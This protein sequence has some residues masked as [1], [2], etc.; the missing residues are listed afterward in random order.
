MELRTGGAVM[1]RSGGVPLVALLATPLGLADPQILRARRS[2]ED[3]L[4]GRRD[5]LP[6]RAASGWADD[7]LVE[8]VRGP[9]PDSPFVRLKP[10]TYQNDDTGQPRT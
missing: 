7:D 10:D 4:S 2:P 9:P 3:T 1:S 8:H 5:R 6:L